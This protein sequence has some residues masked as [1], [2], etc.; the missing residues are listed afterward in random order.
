[1]AIMV[2]VAPS[3]LFALSSPGVVPVSRCQLAAPPFAITYPEG[4]SGTI[5]GM[6]DTFYRVAIALAKMP[7]ALPVRTSDL[8]L[9]NIDALG[10][11]VVPQS[12]FVGNNVL[13]AI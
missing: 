8:S 10:E 12:Q 9:I 11:H 2:A 4:H 7:D 1:M 3:R 13:I 6:I 5:Y